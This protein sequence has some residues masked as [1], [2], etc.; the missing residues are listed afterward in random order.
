MKHYLGVVVAFVMLLGA[1]LAPVAAHAQAKWEE[2]TP[3]RREALAPLGPQWEK[4]SHD[5][6]K[7]WVGIADRLPTMKPEEQTRVKKNM[8]TWAK[9]TPDQRRVARENYQ[10]MREV[11]KDQRQALHNEYK[12]LPDKKKQELA[13]GADK[14]NAKGTRKAK[15]PDQALAKSGDAAA[16]S[17]K[18]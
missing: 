3:A 15:V 10:K 18:R 9:L 8:A 11:P 16:A 7:K 2:L 13:K 17:V 4:L 5:Q 14:D 6:R 12:K 1:S